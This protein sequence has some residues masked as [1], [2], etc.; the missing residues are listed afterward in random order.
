MRRSYGSSTFLKHYGGVGP[1]VRLTVLIKASLCRTI[2]KAQLT[3]AEVEE[4]WLDIEIIPN[5]RH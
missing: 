5:N 1:F 4:V 3:W 2:G